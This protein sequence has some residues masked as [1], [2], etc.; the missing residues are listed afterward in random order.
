M[1]INEEEE[2]GAPVSFGLDS[3][4]LS[5]GVPR[6]SDADPGLPYRTGVLGGSDVPDIQGLPY[7]TG[8]LGGSDAEAIQDEA[9]LGSYGHPPGSNEAMPDKYWELLEAVHQLRDHGRRLHRI[10][11]AVLVVLLLLLL[12]TGYLLSEVIE[13]TGVNV[14]SH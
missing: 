7:K 3:S 10:V 1:G 4:E 5:S 13:V 12:S 14:S 9:G 2:D 6:G 8:V 11:I